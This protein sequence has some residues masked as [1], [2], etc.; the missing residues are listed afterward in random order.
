MTLKSSGY[1]ATESALVWTSGQSLNSLTDGEW[2][3]LSDEIDNTTDL[4]VM[5]DVRIDLA[6]AAFTGTDS[7]LEAY[8][9]PTIDGTTYPTWTGNVTTDQQENNKFFVDSATTTGTTAAQDMA[10]QR[11]VIPPG[12]YKVGFRNNAG[13]SLAASGNN[14]YLRF[15]SFQDA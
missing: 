5:A 1:L 9:V 6:S 14:A 7:I 3:D 2:T 12:K 4:Y 15:H 8:V 11:I 10:I 13:V